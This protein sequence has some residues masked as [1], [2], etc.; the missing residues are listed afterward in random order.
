MAL[1]F[2]ETSQKHFPVSASEQMLNKFCGFLF[3]FIKSKQR[4]KLL[5]CAVC[6]GWWNR[7]VLCK[8][9]VYM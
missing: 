7:A 8:S 5:V 9:I 1:Y 4:K 2:E 3:H 6:K